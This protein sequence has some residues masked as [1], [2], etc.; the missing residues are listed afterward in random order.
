MPNISTVDSS[1][2]K[3]DIIDYFGEQLANKKG[4]L[5]KKVHASLDEL[6]TNIKE[7][8]SITDGEIDTFS[9]KIEFTEVEQEEFET[10][11]NQF[12]K[13][14]P[15]SRQGLFTKQLYDFLF[16]IARDEQLEQKFI[17]NYQTED[18]YDLAI[19][20]NKITELETMNEFSF[21]GNVIEKHLDPKNSKTIFFIK[22]IHANPA[23]GE[24]GYASSRVQSN[25]KFILSELYKKGISNKILMEGY[26]ASYDQKADFHPKLKILE[27]KHK[28]GKAPSF[29][30]RAK[31]NASQLFVLHKGKTNIFVAY[32]EDEKTVEKRL[33]HDYEISHADQVKALI[34]SISSF[35]SESSKFYQLM[36]KD[37]DGAQESFKK[38]KRYARIVKLEFIKPKKNDAD[39]KEIEIFFNKIIRANNKEQAFSILKEDLSTIFSAFDNLPFIDQKSHEVRQEVFIENAVNLMESTGDHHIIAPFG[40]AHF[41]REIGKTFQEQ[42][43]E[44][45]INYVVIEPTEYR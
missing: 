22:N 7:H 34:Y 26:D 21:Q 11:L 4:K 15:L 31:F 27:R 42:C 41:T 25:T 45:G 32:G 3:N 5:N 43:K 33:T 40:G 39:L 23:T 12:L 13:D 14:H 18:K 36:K 28:R 44:K 29:N 37:E 17:N 10:Q 8:K 6:R 38:L 2:D 30:L 1:D 19:L 16:Q 24:V 20:N 9:N 35:S